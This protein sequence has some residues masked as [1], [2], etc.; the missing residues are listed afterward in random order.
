VGRFAVRV[1][2]GAAFS[3]LWVLLATTAASALPQAGPTAKIEVGAQ[4]GFVL[5]AA[6]SIW[7]TD[8]ALGR[9]VRVDPAT[10]AVVARI[11]FATRPFGLAFGAGSVWVADRSQNVLGRVDPRTNRVVKRI[12]IGFS[13]YGVAFGAGSVWASADGAAWVS[14]SG[15]GELWR[16][17]QTVSR[18]ARLTSRISEAQ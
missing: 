17:P 5:P 3:V 9:V 16:L 1:K 14:N 2:Y 15:D 10:N 11:P 13:P 4:A 6:G 8:L 18:R 12:R 7:T